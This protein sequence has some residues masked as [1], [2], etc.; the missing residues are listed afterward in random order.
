MMRVGLIERFFGMALTAISSAANSVCSLPPCGGGLGR[1]VVLDSIFPSPLS[2]SLPRK[3]GGNAVAPTF[4]TLETR[5]QL[6]FT[7]G[8]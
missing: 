4:A 5:E 8:R 1:G 6:D 2:L 3:G 7:L